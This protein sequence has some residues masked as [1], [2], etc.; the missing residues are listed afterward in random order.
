[1]PVIEKP[2]KVTPGSIL[3]KPLFN[4]KG[5]LLLPRG[6]VLDNRSIRALMGWKVQRVEVAVPSSIRGN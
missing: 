6:A 3:A 4:S 2:A 5:Q 1:M